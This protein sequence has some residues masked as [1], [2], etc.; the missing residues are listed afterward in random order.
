V[1]FA[2]SSLLTGPKASLP[3][4]QQYFWQI[5]N[6][7]VKLAFIWNAKTMRIISYNLLPSPVQALAYAL[8]ALLAS[9]RLLSKW[10]NIKTCNISDTPD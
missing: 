1:N 9:F 4:W 7:R 10:L 6:E 5:P 3:K 2:H 8:L